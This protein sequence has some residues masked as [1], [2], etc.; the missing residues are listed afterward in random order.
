MSAVRLQVDHAAPTVAAKV[1]AESQTAPPVPQ[2]APAAGAN[3]F[4][5]VGTLLLAW[6]GSTH[7][8]I[9]T[10]V[11]VRAGVL[12]ECSASGFAT[13]ADMDDGNAADL[14]VGEL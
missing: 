5:A 4:D 6:A 9:S 3:E 7:Q 1:A 8:A 10:A 13:V 11:R 14:R 12:G 2:P